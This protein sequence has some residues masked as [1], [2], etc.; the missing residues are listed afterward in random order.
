[1][2]LYY[3]KEEE[4]HGPIST[5]E[6]NALV[7]QGVIQPNTLVWKEGMENWAP[8]QDVEN[9]FTKELSVASSDMAQ[10]IKEGADEVTGMAYASVLRRFGALLIDGVILTVI[11]FVLMQVLGTAAASAN[12]ENLSSILIFSFLIPT[13]FY[14][15]YHTFFVGKFQAT[16]GKMMLKMKIVRSDGES[17]SYLRAF[18]RYWGTYLSGLILMIGYIMALFDKPENRALHDRLCDTRVVMK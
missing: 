16:P 7:A 18:G 9:V 13:L 15:A 12:S 2:N 6:F 10:R 3:S 1:M 4:R 11:N 14:V 5:E 8:Y 17:L